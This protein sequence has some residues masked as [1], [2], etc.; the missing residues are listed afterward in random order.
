M[1]TFN[2]ERYGDVVANDYPNG[3]ALFADLVELCEENGW[4]LPSQSDVVDWWES[5]FDGEDDEDEL[6]EIDFDVT[7]YGDVVATRYASGDELYKAVVG[8]CDE[9]NPRWAYPKYSQVVRWWEAEMEEIESVRRWN[10]E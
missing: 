1:S 10:E 3:A 6:A 5:Q 2:P 4:D 7:M 8:L 9:Q